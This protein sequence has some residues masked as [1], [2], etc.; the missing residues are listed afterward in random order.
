MKYVV[1][2]VALLLLASPQLQAD[3]PN[4]VTYS[5]RLTDGTGWGESATLDLTFRLYSSASS[6]DGVDLLWQKEY[7]SLAVEDG[8][9][10]V[11]LGAGEDFEVQPL[12]VTAVFATLDQTWIAVCVGEF[13]CGPGADLVPRQHIGSVPYAVR[14]ENCASLDGQNLKQVQG[15]VCGSVECPDLPGYQSYCNEK[16]HCEYVRYD[17]SGWRQW[18]VWIYIA[19]GNFQMGSTGEGGSA[20]E[21][22]VHG[23][24]IG[25]GYFISKYE[26]VVEQHEACIA[27]GG[28]C[29]S[30]STVDWDGNGWGTNS[31]SNHGSTHPQN[32]LT[33]QQS[34][35]FC[36]WVTPGGRLPSES[37]WEYAATGPVHLKYPWGDS[38]DPTCSNNTAVF[39]EAGGTGGYGCSDGGTWP[40]GS[41][42]A[43]VSWCGALDMSGNLW[44]WCEDWWHG[45][46]SGAPGDGSAWLDLTGS[47]RV[48]RGGS[49][50]TAAVSVRSARRTSHTPS[51]R[52][53]YL[54]ARCVRPLP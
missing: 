47:S 54:G 42:S 37:E 39:N 48:L 12:N 24:T 53:A 23:V 6:S 31:S 26:I 18:D 1:P 11:L 30:P 28:S 16:D 2:I 25:Y 7:P 35:D 15:K 13:P 46:Y 3:V 52:T 27:D 14:A 22:P 21:T 36:A 38:P 45:D 51:N 43:G 32:G 44:E 20:N 33:W 41:K 10:S 40:V 49:F 9:F 29:S 8:Y 5:G 19:P 50:T 34:K 17:A 4:F